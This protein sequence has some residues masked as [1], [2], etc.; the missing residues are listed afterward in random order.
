MN[1]SINLENLIERAKKIEERYSSGL[2]LFILAHSIKENNRHVDLAP[3]S[4]AENKKFFLDK[5]YG[6][7]DR[8]L[9]ELSK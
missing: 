7:I 9:I 1:I 3:S 6:R 5:T 2:I 8:S 4:E